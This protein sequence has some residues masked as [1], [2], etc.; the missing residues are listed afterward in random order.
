MILVKFHEKVVAV[1]DS[2]LVGKTFEEDG[3]CLE[4]NEQFYKGE[5]KSDDEVK[6]ILKDADNVNIV[7]EKSVKLAIEIGVVSE[8]GVIRVKG[9]P[10]A[11][12]FAI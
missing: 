4:V 2:E 9:I 8:D 12:V 11:L 3:K 6:D 5:E 1:C 7:G 10:H